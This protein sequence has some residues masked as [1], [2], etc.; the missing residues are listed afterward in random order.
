MPICQVWIKINRYVDDDKIIKTLNFYNY[1]AWHYYYQ[2]QLVMMKLFG[3]APGKPVE[4]YVFVFRQN[5]AKT[6]NV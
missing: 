3:L 1:L 6:A 4:F 5:V 2:L